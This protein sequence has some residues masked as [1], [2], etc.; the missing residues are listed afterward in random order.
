MA[1]VTGD[2]I[3]AVLCGTVFT[4][5]FCNVWFFVVDT[6]TGSEMSLVTVA[7]SLE[8]AIIEPLLDAQTVNT[9][10][11]RIQVDNVTNGIDFVDVGINRPG[12]ISASEGLPSFA[13]FQVK[14]GRGS[15]IT[16]NGYKRFPGLAE[17]S[18]VGQQLTTVAQTTLQVIANTW[19]E[20][21]VPGAEGGL[22]KPVIMGRN[23]DGT[24]DLTRWQIPASFDLL[25]NITT[26]NTRKAGRG[27]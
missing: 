3:R 20:I 21:T 15:K 10:W 9:V 7:G 25:P 22:I 24:P 19:D 8:D 2:I 13:S 4:E 11:N 18:T 27:S 12:T 1:T 23:S 6:L 26:Q 5:Q 17:V 14:M 16:R